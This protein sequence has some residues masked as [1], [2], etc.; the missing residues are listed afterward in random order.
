MKRQCDKERAVI[1]TT[2]ARKKLNIHMQKMNL[3]PFLTTYT[4]INSKCITDLSV[5]PKNIRLLEENTG[6]Q[7]L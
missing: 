5:K 3:N 6:K 7:S 1:T 2:G 4:K